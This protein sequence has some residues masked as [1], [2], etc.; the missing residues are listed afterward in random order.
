[1]N[2]ELTDLGKLQLAKVDQ[3]W[4]F[5]KQRDYDMNNSQ[6]RSP[7]LNVRKCAIAA[8]VV[9]CQKREKESA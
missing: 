2:Y 7:Y 6:L 5:K 3:Y 1:M 4:P 9:E 8:L